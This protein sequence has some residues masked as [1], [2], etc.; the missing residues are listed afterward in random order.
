[1]T[2]SRFDIFGPDTQHPDTAT[3]NMMREFLRNLGLFPIGVTQQEINDLSA[4]IAAQFGT[5]DVIYASPKTVKH[6]KDLSGFD[7]ILKP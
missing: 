1:M 5:P 4:A 3:K 7:D 2:K 6:L